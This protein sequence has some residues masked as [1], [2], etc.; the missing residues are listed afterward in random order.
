MVSCKCVVFGVFKTCPCNG[1]RCVYFV[2]CMSC[3]FVVQGCYASCSSMAACGAFIRM[4]MYILLCLRQFSG[5][6][7][8][9]VGVRSSSFGVSASV[10]VQAGRS[11]QCSLK[12]GAWFRSIEPQLGVA[13]LLAFAFAFRASSLFAGIALV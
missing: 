7:P 1:A 12:F 6:T 2:L 10:S 3:L 9:F 5:G 4:L 8:F 11:F 13:L